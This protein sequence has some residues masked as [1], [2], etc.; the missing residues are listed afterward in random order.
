MQNIYEDIA[1]IKNNDEL[2]TELFAYKDIKIE[3]IVSK[4]F[5]NGSWMLQDHDEWTVL[6]KGEALLEFND[7]N[8]SLKAGD[9]IFIKAH[10][11][12]R[13]LETSESALWLA[14]HFKN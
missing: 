11:A 3:R 4:S 6:I 2:F 10:E 5:K 9:H 13:V 1:I 7:R 14:V 12:H 8:V